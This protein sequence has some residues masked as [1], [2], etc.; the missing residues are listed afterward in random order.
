MWSWAQPAWGSAV[1]IWGSF[2]L[3]FGHFGLR[4]SL[5]SLHS[6]YSGSKQDKQFVR[7]VPQGQGDSSVLQGLRSLYQR[8]V[9]VVKSTNS[10]TSRVYFWVQWKEH[11]GRAVTP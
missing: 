7:G 11:F 4:V 5:L 8:L 9:F 6:P 2:V 10:F 1:W 3:S